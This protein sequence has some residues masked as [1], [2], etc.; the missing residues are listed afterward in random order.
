MDDTPLNEATK[1]AEI[2]AVPVEKLLLNLH[3]AAALLGLPASTLHTWSWQGKVPCV[4]FGRRR[5]FCRA[6]LVRW[7]ELH[8]C[9][10][11]GD[12]TEALTDLPKARNVR[13]RTPTRERGGTSDGRL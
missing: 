7:V 9:P 13:Q 11:T 10:V 6:D 8:R 3:E 5:L 2:P 12:D 1:P 4:R